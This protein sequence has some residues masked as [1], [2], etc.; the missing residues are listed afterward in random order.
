[1]LARVARV[2]SAHADARRKLEADIESHPLEPQMSGQLLELM[3]MEEMA[4]RQGQHDR[5][6]QLTAKVDAQMHEET[7]GALAHIIDLHKKQRRGVYQKLAAERQK[8]AKSL[9]ESAS[10]LCR[11]LSLPLPAK[12][13]ACLTAPVRRSSR[14]S[15]TH[16]PRVGSSKTITSLLDGARAVDPANAA[17]RA[18]ITPSGDMATDEAMHRRQV[19]E[20]WAEGERFNL[21][22]AFKSQMD[23]IEADWESYLQDMTTEYHTERARLLGESVKTAPSRAQGKENGHWLAKE[24]QDTLIHTAPVLAP[25]TS[26]HAATPAKKASAGAAAGTM[27]ASTR[28]ELAALDGRY[29]EAKRQVMVQQEEALRWTR[30]QSERMISQVDAQEVERRQAATAETKQEA[31]FTLLVQAVQDVA[32]RMASAVPQLSSP[33]P[34]GSHTTTTTAADGAGDVSVSSSD[35]IT[36]LSHGFSSTGSMRSADRASPPMLGSRPKTSSATSRHGH[37]FPGTSSS[38]SR[39]NGRPSEGSTS[40]SSRHLLKSPVPSTQGGARGG[41][42]STMGSSKSTGRLSRGLQ[43]HQRPRSGRAGATMNGRQQHRGHSRSRSP[44]SRSLRSPPNSS[45]RAT[46]AAVRRQARLSTGRSAGGSSRRLPSRQ[47]RSGVHRGNNGAAGSSRRCGD[48]SD[49]ALLSTWPN[50]GITA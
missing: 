43:R 37:G 23:R 32:R 47:R 12:S 2:R 44:V 21:R 31:V 7:R 8:L 45:G 15:G 4:G 3:R 50:A 11:S 40:W 46:A 39:S 16:L 35:R 13:L 33:P 24:K 1:M 41:G 48:V 34:G 19:A 20:H 26:F 9:H 18:P 29:E 17:L 42:P 30:R 5:K 49:V 27:S 10:D 38:S 22:Q 36:P 6:R 25:S 28:R 14:S